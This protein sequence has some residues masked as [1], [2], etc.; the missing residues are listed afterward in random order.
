MN[1]I[2]LCIEKFQL[3]ELRDHKRVSSYDCL[4]QMYY[5]LLETSSKRSESNFRDDNND[6]SNIHS[7]IDLRL[8]LLPYEREF[9]ARYNMEKCD[10]VIAR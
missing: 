1:H 9:A 6:D 5:F 10:V 3:K 2:S 8:M 4:L 7:L